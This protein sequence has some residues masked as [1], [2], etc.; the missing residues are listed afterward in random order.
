M[1]T[2]LR[3]NAT[4]ATFQNKPQV[5]PGFRIYFDFIFNVSTD[6]AL[7]EAAAPDP[8]VGL[9][10]VFYTFLLISILYSRKYPSCFPLSA[11]YHVWSQLFE[12]KRDLMNMRKLIMEALNQICTKIR[13][14]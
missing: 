6:P 7:M 8:T 13:I 2:A 5:R 10:Y 14:D 1:E 9:V 11:C 3:P 4:P 12:E